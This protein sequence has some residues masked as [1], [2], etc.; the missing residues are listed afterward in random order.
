MASL[1]VVGLEPWRQSGGAFVVGVEHLVVGPFGLQGAV[2]SLDLAVLPRAVRLDR[3]VGCLQLFEERSEGEASGV[4]PVVV[5]HDC[6][7]SVDAMGGEH[8]NGPGE[9][10]SARR[11]LF[12]GQD[13]GVGETAVVVDYRVHEIE[14]DFGF[15][16]AWVL[17]I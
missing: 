10:R 17:L 13:F 14:P 11:G 7:D 16:W 9:K 15:F 1:S 5:G 6:L 2:E 3:D 8:G 4:A 12:V